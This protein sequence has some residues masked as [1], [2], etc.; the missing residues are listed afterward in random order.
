M[1]SWSKFSVGFRITCVEDL[2]Y[3]PDKKKQIFEEAASTEVQIGISQRFTSVR[4]HTTPIAVG[5]AFPVV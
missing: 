1:L 4:C 3:H 5:V 2:I